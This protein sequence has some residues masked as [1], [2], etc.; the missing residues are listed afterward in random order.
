M[1]LEWIYL[2]QKRERWQAVVN[3]V[4]NLMVPQY[5]GNSLISWATISFSRTLYISRS[6]QYLNY[7]ALNGWWITNL[8]GFES[9]CVP[10]GVL[11]APAF[12]WRTEEYHERN[13]DRWYPGRDWNR[14]PPEYKTALRLHQ[15]VRSYFVHYVYSC[16][17]MY[18]HNL[19]KFS[20]EEQRMRQTA[21]VYKG[22]D[23]GYCTFPT[24]ECVSPAKRLVQMWLLS[25]C[26]YFITIWRDWRTYQKE[27]AKV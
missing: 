26:G 14:V 21:A 6:R 27:R 20:N 10:V 25:P 16:V 11:T 24:T 23:R 2:A 8:K 22:S 19:F 7:T 18:V 17:P 15:P 1:D 5:P 13:Q 12:A 4:M 3:T 9:F